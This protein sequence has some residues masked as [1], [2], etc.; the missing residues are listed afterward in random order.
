MRFSFYLLINIFFIYTNFK[1]HSVPSLL[2]EPQSWPTYSG[3]KIRRAANPFKVYKKLYYKLLFQNNW[4]LCMKKYHFSVITVLGVLCKRPLCID[5]IFV[6]CSKRCFAK[7]RGC[8]IAL[9]THDFHVYLQVS[10]II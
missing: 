1:K 6:L 2:C 7:T 8:H 4:F 5:V 10:Q 9:R 3:F